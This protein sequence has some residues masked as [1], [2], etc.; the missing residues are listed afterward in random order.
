MQGSDVVKV[1][2]VTVSMTGRSTAEFLNV[3]KVLLTSR[4]QDVPMV[5]F[6]QH[7]FNN[8]ASHAPGWC[9]CVENECNSMTSHV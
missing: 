1:L 3:L 9:P 4:L 2:N 7:S 5:R 6:R 8:E